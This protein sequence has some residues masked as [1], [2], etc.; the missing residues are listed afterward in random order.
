MNLDKSFDFIARIT[1]KNS[2]QGGRTTP[3]YS[4][5]RSQI[6]FNF[7]EMQTSG[8]QTLIGKDMVYPGESIDVGI[9]ITSP[10]IY[11]N[12]LNE[13]TDFELREGATVI[14]TGKILKILNNELVR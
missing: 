5:Y 3:I 8:Q 2:Q 9:I 7:T 1:Y 6:K 10:I 4:G 14:G 12:S 13:G 11:E